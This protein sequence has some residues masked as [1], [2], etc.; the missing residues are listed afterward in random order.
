MEIKLN[1]IRKFEIIEIDNA[2]YRN[3]FLLKSDVVN[4]VIG[5]ETFNILGLLKDKG[6]INV[7]NLN[8]EL[9]ELIEYDL[10]IC[11]EENLDISKSLYIWLHLTDECNLDCNYCYIPSLHSKNKI[12]E[13][14]FEKLAEVIIRDKA[15]YSEI[16]LKLAGGEPF[17]TLKSWQAGFIFF[18]EQMHK[19]GIPLYTRVITNLTIMNDEVISFIQNYKVKLSFSIDSLSQNNSRVFYKKNMNS[20]AKVLDNLKILNSRNI[21]PSAMITVDKSNYNNIKDLVEYLI[22]NDIVFRISDDKGSYNIKNEF[23]SAINQTIDLLNK[24]ANNNKNIKYKFLIS[25]LNTL[26]PKAEPCSMGKTGTAI[27]MNGDIFFC[28]TEFGTENRLG[29]L[30]SIGSLDE[31]IRSGYHKHLNLSPDCDKCS[32]RAICAGGCPLFRLNGKSPQC[33]TYQNIIKNVTEL[34]EKCEQ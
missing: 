12:K 27:Y 5:L 31:I 14:F 15:K 4:L 26:Y 2:Y 33:S 7:G 21:I 9:K 25:D 6:K 17:L 10:V 8:K 34:Y 29:N 22:E 19:N 3:L 24:A 1:H 11:S 16:N 23:E 20:S 32:Y 28:H 13:G 30:W 18:V